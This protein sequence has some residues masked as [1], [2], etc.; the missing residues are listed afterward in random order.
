MKRH[1]NSPVIL[2]ERSEPKD[3]SRAQR[4]IEP[5]AGASQ[6]QVGASQLANRF[7][8]LRSFDC[9]LR[10]PLRMTPRKGP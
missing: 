1:R 3:L 7:A 9:G 2:S 6:P 4:Q 5:K 10:P 8:I